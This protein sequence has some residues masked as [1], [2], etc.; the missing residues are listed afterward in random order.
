MLRIKSARELSRVGNVVTC[1]VTVDLPWPMSDLTAVTRAVH[2]VKDNFW[3]RRWKLVK[4]DY[5]VNSGSWTL[6][7]FDGKLNRTYVEYR[8]HAEPKNWVPGWL[9]TRAQKSTLPDLIKK[10]R[11]LTRS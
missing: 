8:V 1:T 3:Q 5:K 9:R 2:T 4:G 6:R 7:T 10:I 11:K